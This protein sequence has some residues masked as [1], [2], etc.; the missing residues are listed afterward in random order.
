LGQGKLAKVNKKRAAIDRSLKDGMM[1]AIY[2]LY[3]CSP[4]RM[5]LINSGKGGDERPSTRQLTEVV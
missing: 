2:R 3:C 4:S 5:L 1:G